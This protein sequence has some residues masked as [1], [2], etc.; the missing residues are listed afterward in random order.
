MTAVSRRA[1]RAFG[2][3]AAILMS[4]TAGGISATAST[5]V[6]TAASAQCAHNE[7][8]LLTC[9]VGQKQLSLCRAGAA[10]ILYSFSGPQGIE[11]RLYRAAGDYEYRP[12]PGIGRT[13]W[14]SVRFSNGPFSYEVFASYDKI[15]QTSAAGVSVLRAETELARFTCDDGSGGAFFFDPLYD[16]LD[17]AGYCKGEEG[18]M[19][20]GP[21]A[22]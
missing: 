3:F 4:L 7:E 12:W 17:A 9:S 8:V 6:S 16:A 19:E 1:R 15:D 11:L 5:A 13:I 21:C 10:D 22:R 20:P 2:G 14:E 18:V